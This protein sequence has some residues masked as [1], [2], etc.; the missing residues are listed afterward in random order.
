MHKGRSYPGLHDTIVE[1]DL[2]DDAQAILAGNRVERAV[3]SKAA[4]PSL[5][6]GLVFDG[7][8]ER[9]S[10]THAVKHGTRYRYYVSQSLIKRGRSK[11]SDAA[12]RVP[13][14]DLE[15]LVEEKIRASMKEP[16]AILEWR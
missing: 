8:G 2:W 15:A 13:A 16:S 3:R 14:A 10:P 1:Q 5:L 7:N 11:P 9:M 4:D 6:A 12:C